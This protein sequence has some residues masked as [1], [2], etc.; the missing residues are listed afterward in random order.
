M[1]GPRGVAD[2]LVTL[3]GLGA[4]AGGP[5]LAGGIDDLWTALAA[6]VKPLATVTYQNLPAT[7]LFID[8]SSFSH[9]PFPEGGSLHFKPPGAAAAPHP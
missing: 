6:E 4:A 7:G 3:S 1:P 9:L 2:D 8:G 5:A